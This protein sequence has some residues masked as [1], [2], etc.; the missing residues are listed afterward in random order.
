[1][2]NHQSDK[3]GILERIDELERAMPFAKE[4]EMIEYLVARIKELRDKL[5]KTL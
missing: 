1:M 5:D 3:M 2:T 4:K